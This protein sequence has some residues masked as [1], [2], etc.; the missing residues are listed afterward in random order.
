MFVFLGSLISLFYALANRESEM[1]ALLE[2]ILLLLVMDWTN[3]A[4]EFGR[5]EYRF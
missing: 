1:N 3:Y 2:S 4:R 5:R